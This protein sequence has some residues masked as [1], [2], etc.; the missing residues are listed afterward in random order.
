[1]EPQV[2]K[3]AIREVHD[4]LLVFC[5]SVFRLVHVIKLWNLTCQGELK[6]AL[7]SSTQRPSSASS[8][9]GAVACQWRRDR[10]S[11]NCLS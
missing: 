11:R 2:I 7:E 1:M 10:N 4:V 3:Q 9:S 6:I 8:K 5:Q